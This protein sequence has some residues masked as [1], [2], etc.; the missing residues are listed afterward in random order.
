MAALCR[1][2]A[3]LLRVHSAALVS[4]RLAKVREVLLDSAMTVRTEQAVVPR[5]VLYS[6]RCLDA[7]PFSGSMLFRAVGQRSL[8]V[9]DLW[10]VNR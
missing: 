2:A 6:C 9:R 5:G 8:Q 10:L 1:D 3:T 7:D 4:F